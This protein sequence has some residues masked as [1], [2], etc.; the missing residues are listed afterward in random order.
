VGI[1]VVNKRSIDPLVLV[2]WAGSNLLY[3][4]LYGSYLI[5]TVLC[6]NCTRLYNKNGLSQNKEVPVKNKEASYEF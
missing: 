1:F 5:G 6:K 4:A 2:F 3:K